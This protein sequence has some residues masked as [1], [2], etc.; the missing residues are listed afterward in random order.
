MSSRKFNP[1]VSL[2]HTLAVKLLHCLHI[3]SIR[4]SADYL[5]VCQICAFGSL[6]CSCGNCGPRDLFPGLCVSTCIANPPPSSRGAVCRLVFDPLDLSVEVTPQNVD[7]ALKKNNFLKAIF[8][9]CR[10]ANFFFF[11]FLSLSFS[12]S[13]FV[14]LICYPNPWNLSE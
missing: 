4:L 3:F 10:S 1:Q 6:I 13:G 8:L 2:R 7:E 12:I 5:Q 11:Q 9:S 14:T